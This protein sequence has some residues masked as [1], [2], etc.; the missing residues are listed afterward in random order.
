MGNIQVL[1]LGKAYR[2]YPSP[3]ARLAEWLDPRRRPRHRQRWVLQDVSFAVRSGESVGIVGVNGAGKS[4]LLKMITGT[5]QPTVGTVRTEGRIAAL[6][7]LGLGFHGDFTG[8]QNVVM[9]GQMMGH[10]LADIARAMPEIESFAEIGE[11]IDQ[12]VRVYSSGMQVR[13]AFAVAVAYRPDILIVDEALAVGDV[14][15]QQKCYERIKTYVDQGTT[16]LFVTH[17][18]ATMLEVC[19][20]ALYLRHGRL[21]F[22]GS[23]KEAVDLYQA[24]LLAA[25]DQGDALITVVDAPPGPGIQSRAAA[26]TLEASGARGSLTTDAVALASVELRTEAGESA[27][28]LLTGR[29]AELQVRYRLR[30]NLA[31]P[32][33]GFKI[34]NR[35]G[36]VVFETNTYCMGAGLGPHGAGTTLEVSFRFPLDLVPDD[37]TVTVGLANRGSG[38]GVFDESLSYLHDVL[39]FRILPDP[40][41]ILW[42]GIVNLRPD[43]SWTAEPNESPAE[44]PTLASL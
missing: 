27:A 8:R 6:L 3:R 42:D 11:Y 40:E 16:L 14:Y 38:A 17:G 2:Q 22:D 31:D 37:Y 21:A 18:L 19:D 4:T 33:V 23:P 9:S 12:P 26:T 1:N 43:L 39:S 32:H 34:R 36:R 13:L 20:R 15:F 24:D 41:G 30:R 35:L 29:R 28:V 25:R 10:S 44:S 5:V 7:E